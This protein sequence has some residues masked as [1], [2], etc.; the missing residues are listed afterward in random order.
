MTSFLAFLLLFLLL[1]V[2]IQAGSLAA[3]WPVFW[4]GEGCRLEST[5]LTIEG[6]ASQPR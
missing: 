5:L 3:V 1:V 6:G 4:G 2:C